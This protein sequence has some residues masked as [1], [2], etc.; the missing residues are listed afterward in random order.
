[1]SGKYLIV[2]LGNPGR[3]Y[4]QTRHNVGF[5]VIDEL[6]KRHNFSDFSKERKAL[7]STGHFK[8]KLI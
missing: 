6:A 7:V 2:G 4:A 1:M 3:D 5:W 8:D